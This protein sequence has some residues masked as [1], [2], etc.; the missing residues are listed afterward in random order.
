MSNP[1]TFIAEVLPFKP[2]FKN[3]EGNNLKLFLDTHPYSGSIKAISDLFLWRGVKCGTYK[4]PK[5]KISQIPTPFI[6]CLENPSEFVV[7]SRTSEDL[8]ELNSKGKATKTTKISFYERWNGITML[9]FIDKRTKPSNYTLWKTSKA[10]KLLFNVLIIS[11]VII[12]SYF[13]ASYSANFKTLLLVSILIPLS[14]SYLLLIKE[15]GVNNFIHNIVCNTN[16][17]L[18]CNSA[19]SSKLTRL[20]KWVSLSQL[21]FFFF[22]FLSI[23]TLIRVVWGIEIIKIVLTNSILCLIISPFSLFLILY[24]V[25]HIKKLCPYCLLVN[26]TIIVFAISFFLLKFP[27]KSFKIDT[28]IPILVISLLI[29]LL[30]TGITMHLLSIQLKLKNYQNA[31]FKLK[32]NPL[33]FSSIMATTKE[34]ILIED[35]LLLKSKMGQKNVIFILDLNCSGCSKAIREYSYILS[36]I[37]DITLSITFMINEMQADHFGGFIN[38]IYSS[39]KSGAD[40]FTLVEKWY[41]D[42]EF[43]KS[44]YNLKFKGSIADKLVFY[45]KKYNFQRSPTLVMDNCILPSD[46]SYYDLSD[47]LRTK[48]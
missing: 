44:Y 36:N 27:E 20:F 18:N 47:F 17:Y 14:A 32:R 1:N 11:I 45:T 35:E 42:P 12:L 25:I 24:Q 34:H 3:I 16:S 9:P 15:Y 30:S 10:S 28:D 33:V 38:K 46:Y 41:E 19:N 21:G 37:G 8:V 29:V 6:A 22:S 7:V 48:S 31:Y 4:L 5:E 13:L 2:L 23:Y 26:G 43:R 39:Y 40:W